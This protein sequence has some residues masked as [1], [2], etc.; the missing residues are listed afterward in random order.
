MHGMPCRLW[1]CRWILLMQQVYWG[2][3][4]YRRSSVHSMYPGFLQHREWEH[5]M[6]SMSYRHY[7]H[8]LWLHLM[9]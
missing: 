7:L 4:F 3:L 2:N 9:Q 5:S 8:Y 1:R 6:F